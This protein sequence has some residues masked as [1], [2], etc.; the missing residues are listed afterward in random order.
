MLRTCYPPEDAPRIR[1]GIRELMA[2]SLDRQVSFPPYSSLTRSAVQ[3][4]YPARLR[5]RRDARLAGVQ[6]RRP[7][8][9]LHALARGRAEYY[10]QGRTPAM[11]STDPARAW[12]RARLAST[13]NGVGRSAGSSCT[14]SIQLAPSIEQ[15]TK[16]SRSLPGVFLVLTLRAQLI[17]D[18]AVCLRFSRRNILVLSRGLLVAR[19]CQL[20]SEGSC[21][22][23]RT[24]TVLIHQPA[25]A[26][27][28]GG[29]A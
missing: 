23:Y 1:L 16:H 14:R 11:S 5:R 15:F 4:R 8:L 9:A 22:G 21:T 19:P 29:R 26:A 25:S 6:S 24:A 10:G 28:P 17:G 7:K 12:G 3:L 20:P 2:R 18:C 13:T 27:R